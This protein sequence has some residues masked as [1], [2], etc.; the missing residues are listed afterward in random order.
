TMGAA[1]SP[2]LR[3]A[4]RRV[5]AGHSIASRRVLALRDIGPG[6]RVRTSGASLPE[7]S[8]AGPGNSLS[9][10]IVFRLSGWRCSCGRRR[11]RDSSAADAIAAAMLG[12]IQLL[13]GAADEIVGGAIGLLQRGDADADGH[14]DAVG[15]K[16]E[17]MLGD[18]LPQR[19]P[20]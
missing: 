9:G 10:G 13:V 3:V 16:D 11:S 8:S 4:R 12:L 1:S 18:L 15:L 20:Q 17:Q 2:P 6:G 14:S 7:L 5:K 19:F